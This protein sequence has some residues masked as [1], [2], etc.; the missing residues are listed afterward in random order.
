MTG[1]S[2]YWLVWL[3]IGFGVPE[4]IALVRNPRDTLS[5]QVWDLEGTGA[6]FTRFFVAAFLTWLLLHMVFRIF[7]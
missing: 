7:K 1:W 5:Y 3:V 6:T 4:G 2:W